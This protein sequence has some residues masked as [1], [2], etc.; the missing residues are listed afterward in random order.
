MVFKIALEYFGQISLLRKAHAFQLALQGHQWRACKRIIEQLVVYIDSQLVEEQLEKFVVEVRNRVK[1][2]VNRALERLAHLLLLQ[3][4]QNSIESGEIAE[5]ERGL[6]RPWRETQQSDGTL[7]TFVLEKYWK[8]FIDVVVLESSSRRVC[9]DSV[10]VLW[11]NRRVAL[12]VPFR[13]IEQ[14]FETSQTLNPP[15]SILATI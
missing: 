14:K 4:L 2:L 6:R 1:V 11:H 9:Q 3:H 7:N 5:K 12:H 15:L 10:P 13:K 8:A